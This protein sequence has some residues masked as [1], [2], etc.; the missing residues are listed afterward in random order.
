MLHWNNSIS[1]NGHFSQYCNEISANNIF[2]NREAEFEPGIFK[3]ADAG[4]ELG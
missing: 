3:D 2:S 1:D 4:P